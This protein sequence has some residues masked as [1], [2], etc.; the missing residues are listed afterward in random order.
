MNRLKEDFAVS[1]MLPHHNGGVMKRSAISYLVGIVSGAT[2]L[3]C[4]LTTTG[5]AQIEI[6]QSKTYSGQTDMD[7]GSIQLHN[8]VNR[9]MRNCSGGTLE[10]YDVVVS[11]KDASSSVTDANWCVTTTD[12]EADRKV[13]GAVFEQADDGEWLSVSISGA[14]QVRITSATTANV[15]DFLTTSTTAGEAT[16]STSQQ[17]V[18][19]IVVSS[20]N[21][22]NLVYVLPI[23]AE[24]Y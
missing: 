9:L 12:T 2:L 16:T 8:A 3:F 14:F 6:R 10:R 4:I 5:H 13:I 20:G 18:F 24:T 23:M 7:C 11:G 21:A 22:N 17:G 15:G 19:A 1:V